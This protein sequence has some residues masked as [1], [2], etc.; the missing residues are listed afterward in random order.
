MRSL[1]REHLDRLLEKYHHYIKGDVLDVG[2]KK[3]NKKG[4]FRINHKIIKSL[5]YVN[6]DRKTNPDY[7][8]RAEKI[9]VKKNS[10]STILITEL[11]QY[12][13]DVELVLSE[14]KRV[15]K[16]KSYIICSVPFLVPVHGDYKIDKRRLTI[17]YYK[18]IFKKNNLKI[19]K[20]EYMGSVFSVIHDIILISFGYASLSKN[21][22][23][24]KILKYLRFIFKFLDSYFKYE[25][26]FITSGYFFI[27]QNK[28]K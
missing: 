5:K 26:K 28:K 7:L 8:A 20:M 19:I 13:D 24:L 14:I 15:S 1:R 10:F 21:F 18:K 22:I 9:P 23:F 27:L 2:G 25:S 4:F 11:L 3:K 16:E 6:I 12:V 17:E